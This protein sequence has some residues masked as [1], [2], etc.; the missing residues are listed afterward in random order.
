MTPIRRQ[1]SYPVGFLKST[2][3]EELFKEV[4][5]GLEDTTLKK[6]DNVKENGDQIDRDCS[7]PEKEHILEEKDNCVMVRFRITF[8]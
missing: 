7:S 2:E 3:G 5:R 6:A 4:S 1:Y 8:D